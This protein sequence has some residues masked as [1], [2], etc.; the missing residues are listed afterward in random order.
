MTISQNQRM[1]EQ[2]LRWV[3]CSSMWHR[4]FIS[5]LLEITSNAIKI[6]KVFK[7]QRV[8]STL[9]KYQ[10]VP[11]QNSQEYQ[12][13]SFPCLG[14]RP[15]VHVVSESGSALQPHT[16]LSAAAALLLLNYSYYFSTAQHYWHFPRP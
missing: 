12:E 2:L 3:V 13:D 1:R 6:P 5:A 11:S 15:E 14:A 4:V 7:Y 16:R 9:S 8:P 10:R